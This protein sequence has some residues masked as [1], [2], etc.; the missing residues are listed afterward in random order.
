MEVNSEGLFG[1][2]DC[3]TEERNRSEIAKQRNRKYRKIMKNGV[4]NAGI[5]DTGIEKHE[6]DK[7]ILTSLIIVVNLIVFYNYLAFNNL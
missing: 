1:T 6:S 7:L 5:H 2:K 4:W 3:K